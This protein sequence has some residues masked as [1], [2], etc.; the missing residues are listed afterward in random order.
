MEGIVVFLNGERG[1]HVVE[2]LVKNFH[3]IQAVV[4]TRNLRDDF[5]ENIVTLD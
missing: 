5:R 4:S 3:Q 1:V 2:A